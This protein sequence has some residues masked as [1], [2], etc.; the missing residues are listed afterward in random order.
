M[1]MTQ[2]SK[3][4]KGLQVLAK[5]DFS[6]KLHWSEN[7][8]L[9][10]IARR[11]RRRHQEIAEQREHR[12]AQRRQRRQHSENKH[13]QR[14]R[15]NHTTITLQTKAMKRGNTDCRCFKKK[16]G[17][18]TLEIYSQNYLLRCNDRQ[19]ELHDLYNARQGYLSNELRTAYQPLD[20][21]QQGVLE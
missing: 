20:L 18:A 11:S 13:V 21:E 3:N 9:K 10:F 17:E 5:E 4:N 7:A 16:S 8:D 12:L 6:L 15:E 14:Q 19:Q 2:K 1:Q